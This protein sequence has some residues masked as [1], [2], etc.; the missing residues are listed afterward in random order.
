[1]KNIG[2]F[3]RGKARQRI[4]IL[5]LAA[6]VSAMASGAAF[7]TDSIGWIGPDVI[8]N[9]STAIYAKDTFFDVEAGQAFYLGDYFF[10][11]VNFVMKEGSQ[12]PITYRSSAPQIVSVGKKTGLVQT[13]KT[14][15]A[16]ISAVYKNKT[17]T[18]TL[19]VKKKGS[20]KS[21]STDIK[22][23]KKTSIALG[24]YY[25]KKITSKNCLKIM[26]LDAAFKEASFKTKAGWELY[27]YW[28]VKRKLFAPNA[29]RACLT[30]A[31]LSQYVEDNRIFRY[32][33]SLNVSSVSGTAGS[34]TVTVTL[35]KALTDTQVNMLRYYFSMCNQYHDKKKKYTYGRTVTFTPDTSLFR[36]TS[37]DDKDYN[38]YAKVTFTSGSKE[39]K[40]RL[41]EKENG[42]LT[43]FVLRKGVLY[44][45]K[46]DDTWKND[47]E[48]KIQ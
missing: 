44:L 46:A 32:G 36:F 7:A 38:L 21:T 29:Y 35:S 5:I 12:L 10:S 40:C 19:R 23:L 2:T 4:R 3:F 48:I 9:A 37:N 14:G 11:F 6:L 22:K 25:D 31:S 13:L 27:R 18:C 17:Y 26:K 1:M 39:V 15:S 28:E 45:E 20:L 42:K 30:G 41:F 24:K 47:K 43:P 34:G 8:G 33:K 16:K